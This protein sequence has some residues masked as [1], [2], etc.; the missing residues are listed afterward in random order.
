MSSKSTKIMRME[1]TW[2]E[3]VKELVDNDGFPTQWVSES[4]LA[5]YIQAIDPFLLLCTP[6]KL[7]QL[8]GRRKT[9][10]WV[11]PLSRAQKLMLNQKWENEKKQRLQEVFGDNLQRL[12]KKALM[13]LERGIDEMNVTCIQMAL[14]MA[15][16]WQKCYKVTHVDGQKQAEEIVKLYNAYKKHKR[17]DVKNLKG[18]H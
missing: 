14:E 18:N 8:L 4:N 13:Q 11:L 5:D 3:K 15:G 12:G 16:I 9:G 17:K 10:R 2:R 1:R 6:A 7:H